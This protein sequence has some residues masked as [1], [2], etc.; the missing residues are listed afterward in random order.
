E[1]LAVGEARRMQEDEDAEL[2]GLG[3]EGAEFRGRQLLA[4]DVGADLDAAQAKLL[5]RALELGDGEVG[6][7]ERHGGET[8]KAIGMIGADLRD[9]L[10]NEMRG[11]AAALG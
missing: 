3:E 2:F 7:L 6:R 1:A 10:A 4:I 5:H 9:V 8:D 11:L